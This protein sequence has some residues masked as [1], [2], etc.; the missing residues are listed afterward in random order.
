MS[1]KAKHFLVAILSFA[2]ISICGILGWIIGAIIGG[3]MTGNF[4]YQGLPGYE[5][6]G[7]L[8][9]RIGVALGVIAI[10]IVLWRRYQKGLL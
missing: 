3:N 4:I 5:G 1:M 9:S 7:M 2:G 6:A 8:G 10:S